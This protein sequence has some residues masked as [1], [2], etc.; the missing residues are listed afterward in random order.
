MSEKPIDA[1]DVLTSGDG[2]PDRPTVD[3]SDRGSRIVDAGQTARFV[4]GVDQDRPP[5]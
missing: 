3:D 2:R 5:A 4:V 1:N